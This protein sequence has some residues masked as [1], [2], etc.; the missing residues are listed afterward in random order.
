MS[1]KSKAKISAVINGVKDRENST[2]RVS[3]WEKAME[4]VSVAAISS[5]NVVNLHMRSTPCRTIM[6][7]KISPPVSPVNL[8]FNV[9][10]GF[11]EH[12]MGGN[13]YE[14]SRALLDSAFEVEESDGERESARLNLTWSIKSFLCLKQGTSVRTF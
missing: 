7:R 9:S 11:P 4:I 1:G 3:N 13:A 10:L 12:V 2:A 14:S 8:S 5:C 6:Y